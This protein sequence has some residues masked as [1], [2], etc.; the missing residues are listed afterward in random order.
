MMSHILDEPKQTKF[1]SDLLHMMFEVQG[2]EPPL[3]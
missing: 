1:V 3:E 2:L